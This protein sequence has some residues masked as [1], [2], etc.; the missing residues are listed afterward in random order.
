MDNKVLVQVL[1]P[2]VEISY[3]VFIPISKRIGNIIQLIIKAINDYGEY[4]PENPHAAL[5]NCQTGALYDINS[6]VYDTDIRNGTQIV[7]I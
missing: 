4:Y 1:I 5:Y 3:D 2:D 7:L 6:L